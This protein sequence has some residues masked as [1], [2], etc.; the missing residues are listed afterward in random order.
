MPSLRCPSARRRIAAYNTTKETMPIAT[1]MSSGIAP[2][3]N[4]ALPTRAERPRRRTREKSEHDESDHHDQM[5]HGR[6]Y[7]AGLL[8]GSD[9]VI[10][11]D[12]NIA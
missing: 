2:S 1:Q 12:T 3:E 9:E 7:D 6:L 10:K 8:S 4:D 11:K 5:G